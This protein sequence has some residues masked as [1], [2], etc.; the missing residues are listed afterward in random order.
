MIIAAAVADKERKILDKIHWL[1]GVG[2]IP[3]KSNL[4]AKSW[5]TAH[6]V[7]IQAIAVPST[8]GFGGCTVAK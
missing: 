1:V 8:V 7:R 3:P 6:T 5:N 2:G 4:I